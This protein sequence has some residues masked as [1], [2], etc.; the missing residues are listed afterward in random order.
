MYR[1][2]DDDDDEEVIPIT[3]KRT[4]VDSSPLTTISRPS[5]MIASLTSTVPATTVPSMASVP[6][7]V[8]SVSSAVP[9]I[10]GTAPVATSI[11]R[12][13][14]VTSVRLPPNAVPVLPVLPVASVSLQ[15]VTSVTPLT[16]VP[17][18]SV[19]VSMMHMGT[20]ATTTAVNTAPAS[21]LSLPDSDRL[22]VCGQYLFDSVTIMHER[23]TACRKFS[24]MNI[25]TN[26]AISFIHEN[27][28]LQWEW[29][30]FH[31]CDCKNINSHCPVN[32]L[33]TL[34][35]MLFIIPLV[36]IVLSS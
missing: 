5:G 14:P 17:S 8:T 23:N 2:T 24:L 15:P 18:S 6:F 19:P 11:G 9:S 4:A 10:A 27:W 32:S 36:M 12:S 31:P 26:F 3:S 29:W 28:L 22:D 30:P 35:I 16:G 33:Y 1:S 20:N 7:T 25:S 13:L 21:R 34:D